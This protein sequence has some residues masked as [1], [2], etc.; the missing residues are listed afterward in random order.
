VAALAAWLSPRARF[1]NSA[2][3]D[4]NTDSGALVIRLKH[5]FAGC[6]Y[7]AGRSTP[8]TSH[9]AES[10]GLMRKLRWWCVVVMAIAG[11]CGGAPAQGPGPSVDPDTAPVTVTFLRHDNPAYVEADKAFFED[12]RA[13]HPNVTIDDHTVDFHTLADTLL[14]DLKRDQFTYDL[15][16]VPPSRLCGYAD[17]LLDVPPEVVSLTEAENTFFAAPLEGAT[18]DHKLKGLPIEYNLEYGGVVVNL[19][20]YQAR[21]PGKTPGWADWPSF[22]AEATALAEYDDLGNPCAN[23]LDI[24]PDWHEPVKH[25]FLSEILQRGGDYWAPDHQTFDFST[26]A[27]YDSLADMV[28]WI[29]TSKVMHRKLVPDTNTFVTTRLAAGATGY[30]WGDPARP[31]S[32]MG[33]VGTWGVPSVREQLPPN[34]PWHYDFFPLPPMVG[35]VHKFVQNSGW[36]FAVPRTSKQPKVAWD[37]A[38]SLA[39]SESAMRKWSATTG[40]LPALRANGSPSAA[41]S[42]PT[43]AKVQPLFELGRWIGW[44]PPSAVETVA[45]A[46]LTNFFAAVEGQKTIREALDAMQQT[47]NVA[48]IQ[49]RND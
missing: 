23:G 43:L 35:T 19:E 2:R 20:K 16:L 6:N 24:D 10:E 46:M 4:V 26:Q 9:R 31:L 27:A 34:V 33:Y 47:S 12:Y 37:I 30:G 8:K 17:N 1:E 22:I 29:K 25:I 39:L 11:G 41:Q 15:V 21:F 5:C 49:H 40:A 36:A 14:G 48:I 32:V 7:E 28:E 42:D 13:Q 44:I 3:P 18:C 38:R 45:G